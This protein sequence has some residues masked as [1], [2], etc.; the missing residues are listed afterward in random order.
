MGESR[1]N[2]A[3]EEL[4]VATVLLGFL[5]VAISLLVS[6]PNE[7]LDILIRTGIQGYFNIF[8]SYSSF[9]TWIIFALLFSFVV[10]VI[11]YLVYLN[12]RRGLRVARTFFAIGLFGSVYLYLLICLLFTIRFFGEEGAAVL[13]SVL[14]LGDLVSIPLIFFYLAYL[15]RNVFK[16]FIRAHIN[17]RN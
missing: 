17:K 3:H 16:R 4:Q 8:I 15:W 12:K 9:V 6:M 13:N 11:L 1:D 5:F 7:V 10:S 2:S 14:F